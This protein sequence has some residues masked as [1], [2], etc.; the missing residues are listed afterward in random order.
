L[1]DKH[2]DNRA[3]FCGIEFGLV[4]FLLFS[5]LAGN[6]PVETGS[7]VTAR[8]ANARQPRYALRK[9]GLSCRGFSGRKRRLDEV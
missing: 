8:T 7:Q 5:L 3:D 4:I 9:G 2:L 1:P 6:L